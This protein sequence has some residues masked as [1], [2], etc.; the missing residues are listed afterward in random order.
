MYPMA[1]HTI[2]SGDRLGWWCR[3]HASNTHSPRC[4]DTWF[5]Y[6]N[7]VDRIENHPKT[8]R[9]AILA[10]RFFVTH[11]IENHFY[12]WCS[13]KD[14][15]SHGRRVDS[16][17]CSKCRRIVRKDTSYL[18]NDCFS[19]FRTREVAVRYIKAMQIRC[20]SSR[21][22]VVAGSWDP[23]G[24]S[25]WSS[26]THSFHILQIVMGFLPLNPC[27]LYFDFCQS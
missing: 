11:T 20:L 3:M 19:W 25:V 16:P 4:R 2:T 17:Y 9:H 7:A 21:L 18:A 14:S 6:R 1:L 26:W 10:F 13:A 12:L 23:N 27:K 15:Q 5:D 22:L 24:L 8:R